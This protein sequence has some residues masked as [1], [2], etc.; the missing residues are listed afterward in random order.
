MRKIMQNSAS[1]STENLTKL[2]A[3]IPPMKLPNT[4]KFYKY[5]ALTAKAF[6]R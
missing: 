3:N 6:C 4:A 5:V 1:L 2:Y